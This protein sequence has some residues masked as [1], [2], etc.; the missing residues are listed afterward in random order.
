MTKLRMEAAPCDVVSGRAAMMLQLNSL[1]TALAH[2]LMWVQLHGQ[3]PSLCLTHWC[4]TAG[5]MQHVTSAAAHLRQC[6]VP[7]VCPCKKSTNKFPL[8]EFQHQHRQRAEKAALSGTIRLLWLRYLLDMKADHSTH[9]LYQLKS[10]L[11]SGLSRALPRSPPS[12]SC[13]A[14]LGTAKRSSA[15]RSDRG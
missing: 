3:P 9:F 10:A 7:P 4:G 15:G 14:R 12:M 11:L 6:R 13:S 2:D 8:D 1:L 5:T